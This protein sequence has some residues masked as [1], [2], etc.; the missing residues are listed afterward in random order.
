MPLISK[1]EQNLQGYIIPMDWVI[2]TNY[3]VNSLIIAVFLW[4]YLEKNKKQKTKQTTNSKKKK[5]KPKKNQKNKQTPKQN[6]T[7]KQKSKAKQ[8]KDMQINDTLRWM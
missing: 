3:P 2:H 5:K 6:K 4:R 7:N 8:K 1:Y